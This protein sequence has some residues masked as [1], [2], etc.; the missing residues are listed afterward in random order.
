M[1]W[2]PVL[3]SFLGCRV[4]QGFRQGVRARI[5]GLGGLREKSLVSLAT[6]SYS[7]M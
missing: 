2:L 6:F 3:G 4:E 7:P 5:E 1:L